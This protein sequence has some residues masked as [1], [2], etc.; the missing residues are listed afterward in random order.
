ML[1]AL[2][3]YRGSSNMMFAHACVLTFLRTPS[4]G[5]IGT[6]TATTNLA[7]LSARLCGR[8]ALVLCSHKMFEGGNCSNAVQE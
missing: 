4:T 7:T 8:L 5:K 3:D 6:A 2:D 1:D